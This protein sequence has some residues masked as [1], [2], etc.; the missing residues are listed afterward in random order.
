MMVLASRV[1][2]GPAMRTHRAALQILFDRQLL[3]T[4]TARDGEL[5]ALL[6]RPWFQRMIREFLMTVLACIVC[7][8]ADHL[9]RNDIQRGVIMR[10]SG[11]RVEIH[12]PHDKALFRQWLIPNYANLFGTFSV[13]ISYH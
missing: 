1:E 4:H 6:S 11:L 13:T 12:T 2:A 10:A 9:D 5:V 7:L 3:P 8:A